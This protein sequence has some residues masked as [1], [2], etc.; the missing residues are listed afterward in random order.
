MYAGA[1]AA[2]VSRSWYPDWNKTAV[3]QAVQC[4]GTEETIFDCQ[5]SSAQC[6]VYQDANIIC[7]GLYN[8]IS[9]IAALLPR[10]CINYACVLATHYY[11]RLVPKRS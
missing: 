2:A 10:F 4:N 1:I 8:C 7:Q 9:V 5:S 11:I 6:E 3:I